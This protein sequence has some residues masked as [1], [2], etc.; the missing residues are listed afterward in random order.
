MI[1]MRPASDARHGI[2]AVE[3]ILAVAPV[4]DTVVDDELH[5]HVP[6]GLP[7]VED[8]LTHDSLSPGQ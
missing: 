1:I 6:G 8:V 4:G 7:A 2:V 3:Y 5:D